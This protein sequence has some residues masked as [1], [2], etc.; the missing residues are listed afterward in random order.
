MESHTDLSMQLSK[1]IFTTLNVSLMILPYFGNSVQIHHLLFHLRVK[2][3]EMM[4]ANLNELYL[5]LSSH[6]PEIELTSA[7]RMVRN[8][9]LSY[10]FY[11]YRVTVNFDTEKVCGVISIPDFL[12]FMDR[13]KYIEITKTVLYAD[14]F[15]PKLNTLDNIVLASGY[16]PEKMPIIES[17][18]LIKDCYELPK[19]F[20][21]NKF[22]IELDEMYVLDRRSRCLSLIKPEFHNFKQY[23]IQECNET[24]A[25]EAADFHFSYVDSK[26]KM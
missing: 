25:V 17:S 8:R 15:R 7:L 3:R 24:L 20:K 19:T 18:G 13:Y 14:L 22:V 5:Y 9:D 1:E 21:V 4:A 6:K 16:K 10:A 11:K 23:M 26:T 12:L 2:S